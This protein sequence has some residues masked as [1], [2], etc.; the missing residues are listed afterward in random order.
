MKCR[1]ALLKFHPPSFNALTPTGL[2]RTTVPSFLRGRHWCRKA[3][4]FRGARHCQLWKTRDMFDVKKR[5]KTCNICDASVTHFGQGRDLR[6]AVRSQ[7]RSWLGAFHYGTM[8]HA[9]LSTSFYMFYKY[10]SALLY[11]SHDHF[12]ALNHRLLCSPQPQPLHFFHD[13]QLGGATH[14]LMIFPPISSN[15]TKIFSGLFPVAEA[16]GPLPVATRHVTLS[17]QD[18]H[19]HQ[20]IF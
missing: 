18:W 15:F 4:G 20:F 13:F 10:C 8:A 2:A 5:E 17:R 12:G 19:W 16:A 1:S 14:K 6:C 3:C 7:H 9:A 11:I